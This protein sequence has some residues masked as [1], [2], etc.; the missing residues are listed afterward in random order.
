MPN[1]PLN[2]LIETPGRNID[3]P[4]E[5]ISVNSD[6]ILVFK[7]GDFIFHIDK[8]VFPAGTGASLNIVYGETPAG[9]VNGSNA[10]FT[11]AYDFVPE[12]VQVMINGII[13]KPVA[14]Y[15][16]SGLRTI[17]LSDS[18]NTGETILVTYIKA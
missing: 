3:F 5:L 6:A 9:L 1:P 18:P 4:S 10:T 14:H 8:S 12:K 7:F 17:T 15:N 13:Q 11:T 16:T 2:I